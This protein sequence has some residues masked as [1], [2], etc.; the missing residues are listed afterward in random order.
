MKKKRRWEKMSRWL[1]LQY[2]TSGYL[3]DTNS[4]HRTRAELV[5]IFGA[6]VGVLFFITCFIKLSAPFCHQV[7]RTTFEISE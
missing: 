6:G 3:S 5:M 7:I 4:F 1:W 2:L